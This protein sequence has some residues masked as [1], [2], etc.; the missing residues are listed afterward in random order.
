[1]G[2][3]SDAVGILDG[4][5]ETCRDGEDGFRHAADGVADPS[6]ARLLVSY[7]QQRAEFGQELRKEVVRL[8]HVPAESGYLAAAIHRGWMDPRAVAST[9]E[10]AIVAE[11]ERGEDAAVRNFATA[12]GG[13]LPEAT[14]RIVERQFLQLKEAHEHLR[15]LE[16]SGAGSH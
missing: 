9:D 5:I 6:L 14:R 1:M 16:R 13:W 15:S 3:D 11:C 12:I 8:G 4:L 7:S 2:R 10:A